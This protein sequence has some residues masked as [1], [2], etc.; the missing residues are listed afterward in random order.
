MP[1]RKVAA[2]IVVS[3]I[4]VGGIAVYLAFQASTRSPVNRPPT[5]QTVSADKGA[6]DIYQQVSFTASAMD[7]DGDTLTYEWGFGD[8]MTAFGATATHQFL[9]PGQYIA[10]VTISDGR[11]ATVTSESWPIFVLVNR[12]E[13]PR[14]TSSTAQPNPVAILAADRSMVQVNGTV[15]FNGNSSWSW[16]YDALASAWVF[17]DAAANESAMSAL[18]YNF[19]EDTAPATGTSSQAGTIGHQFKTTGSHFV[20]LSVTNY[21]GKSDVVGYTVRVTPG[22]PPSGVVKNPGIFTDV[23]F[24]EPQSLDPAFENESAGN[25]VLRNVAETLISFDRDRADAFVPQLAT[26]VPNFANPADVSPDGITY[27]LTLNSG[28]TFHSGNPVNCAAVRFSFV[29]VLVLNDRRSPAWI[30]DQSLTDFAEDDPGTSLDERKA[31]INASV[32]C[33]A[34][35]TGLRVQLHLVVPHYGFLAALASTVASVIDPSPDS[36]RVTPQCPADPVTGKPDLMASY[37]HDQ[38]IGTGPFML[39][40][41]QPNQQIILDRN[42]RYWGTLAVFREVHIIKASNQGT[43]VLML[44]AGDADSIS[45]S[46]DSR[47]EIRDVQGNLLPGILEYSRS[48]FAVNFLGFNQ[49]I[50]VAETPLTDGDVPADFF[51]DINLRK[52]F[53]YAWQYDDYIDD[54]LYGYGSRICG[55]IPQGM[56]GYEPT[57]CYG[58]D[59]A[60]AEQHFRLAGDT[61][62]GHSGSYW[63]NGFLMTIYYDSGNTPWE[64]GARR[65]AT[66][67]R[68]LNPLFDLQSV[69]LDRSTLTEYMER[70]ISSVLFLRWAPA[71]ADP[72]DYVARILRT[73]QSYPK[74]V[75]YSNIT[76]DA[77]IDQQSTE[78]DPAARLRLLAE[79]QLAPYYDVPYLWLAQASSPSVFRSWIGGFYSNPLYGVNYYHALTKG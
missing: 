60:R 38:T 58:Y 45:L 71:Y 39:R 2:L 69:A 56:F 21:L 61:R 23:L 53:S 1:W 52:A 55:P 65:L 27:N 14:P 31:V 36:Y 79:I 22:D 50:N 25:Q 19:G 34:G 77:K 47:N 64:E 10:I 76:L 6:V 18:S 46:P 4:V 5:I 33:P 3:A 13:R 9:Y 28:L 48:T 75:N 15:I 42:D 70:R 35:N 49:D 67:L 11:G 72:D 26:K 16:A 66:T 24:G 12:V 57:P 43:R 32:T 54:V 41:W 59:L 30:L 78:L 63:D 62:P 20:R 68:N 17:N 7:P 74:W 73:G 51:T 37:C 40:L 29:R 44:K 8:N